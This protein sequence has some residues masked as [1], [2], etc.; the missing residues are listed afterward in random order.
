MSQQLFTLSPTHE[1][2]LC[3]QNVEPPL[4][5]DRVV[6]LRRT[7][8]DSIINFCLIY[9]FFLGMIFI[10]N[11]IWRTIPSS[12][13]WGRWGNVSLVFFG[14]LFMVLATYG[15]LYPERGA[16]AVATIS[17]AGLGLVTSTVLQFNPV[18]I[19]FWGLAAIAAVYET[20]QRVKKSGSR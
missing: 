9:M 19:L 14:L 3:E 11:P 18:G 7:W 8:G 13:G 5:R 4:L 10:L 1:R 2:T 16:G 20:V 6:R 17:I 15:A 12:V